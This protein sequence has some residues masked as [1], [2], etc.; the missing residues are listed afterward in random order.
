[1]LSREC[2]AIVFP[3][4]TVSAIRAIMSSSLSSSRN[5][6]SVLMLATGFYHKTHVSNKFYL[7]A[8]H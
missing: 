3:Q 2:W 7:A 8:N 1:M 5:S 4:D 6:D